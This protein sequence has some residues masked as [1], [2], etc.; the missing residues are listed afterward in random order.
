MSRSRTADEVLTRFH[1]YMQDIKRFEAA[2]TGLDAWQTD[3]KEEINTYMAT[4]EQQEDEEKR[5]NTLM[6]CMRIATALRNSLLRSLK[7][8]GK[9]PADDRRRD[10]RR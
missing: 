9:K 10:V 3:A 6:E 4:Y 5:Y 1:Q 2:L 7:E 8:Q